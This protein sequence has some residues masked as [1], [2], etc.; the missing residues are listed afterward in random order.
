MGDQTHSFWRRFL[1]I[2]FNRCFTG[3]AA[4]D[5]NIAE[6]ILGA[7]R[8]GVVSWMLEGAVRLMAHSGYTI[9][10][11]HNVELA[12]WQG[13]RDPIAAFVDECTSPAPRSTGT[14]ASA[15]YGAYQT[16]AIEKGHEPVSST[17]FG[18]RLRELEHHPRRTNRGMLY[19]FAMASGEAAR[20]PT[21]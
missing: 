8:P 7:E 5:P 6:R 18:T 16:W 20:E 9:P 4:R 10:A 12:L 13:K 14:L 17:K 21:L 1:I 11:S 19:P 15:L 2:R 3:D